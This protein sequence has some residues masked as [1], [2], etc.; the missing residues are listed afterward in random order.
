[1]EI[2]RIIGK[3]GFRLVDVAADLKNGKKLV[4]YLE[5]DR[6]IIKARRIKKK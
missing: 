4:M 3:L 6:L 5:N 2:E 1:M